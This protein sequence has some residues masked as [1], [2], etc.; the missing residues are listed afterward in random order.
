MS[1]SQVQRD[2]WDNHG[3]KLSRD[4]IQQLSNDIGK[5]IGLSEARWSYHLPEEVLSQTKMVSIGRDGTTTYIRGDG[6]REVM[7]GTISFHNEKGERLHTI[8]KAQAPEYGK[9][10]FDKR[11]TAQI[12]EVKI[13]LNSSLDK[14]SY[15]SDSIVY[16]GLADGAKD[17]WTFLEQHT[18]V[19]IL[20]YWHACEYLTLASKTASKST[21]QQKQWLINARRQLKEDKD[22]PQELLK[23]MKKFKRKHGRSKTAKEGLQRAITYFQNHNQQMNYADYEKQ[24]YPI[25][26][27]VTEAA[28][29]VIVKQRLSRS[30]MKWNIDTSQ[31][32]LNCRALMYSD[33]QWK[34]FWNNIDNYG[35]SDN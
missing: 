3:R 31:Y 34:Q 14:L 16:I 6:Y 11:F 25:G 29:K 32:V 4:Y 12:N 8:Y 24:N 17:N 9:E 27:G 15:L 7:S 2:F 33:T 22:A 5:Q 26:S 13:Q 21:Y 18:D 19:S 30:G 10:T 35:F 23:E 28:C 20:D 1:T